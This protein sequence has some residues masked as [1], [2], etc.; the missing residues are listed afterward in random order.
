MKKV[1]VSYLFEG[2]INESEN[3]TGILFPNGK[4][5]VTKQEVGLYKAQLT[6]KEGVVLV[7]LDADDTDYL[8]EEA[9]SKLID[10]ILA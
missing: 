1:I 6:D 2:I 8:R 9:L 3:E 5:F 10:L 7:N 4:V